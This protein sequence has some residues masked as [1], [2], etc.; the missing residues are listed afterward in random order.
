MNCE[1][2]FLAVGDASKAGDAIV[3]RYGDVSAYELMIVDA[4]NLDSGRDLVNHIRKEFGA[5]SIISHVVLTHCDAD[6]ASGLREVLAELNVRN[7][8]L[9]IPWLCAEAARPYF[10]E[11][12][13]SDNQVA[14]AIRKEYGLIDEIVKLALNKKINIFQP[15]A[16]LK[17]GPFLVVSPY[18][19]A[20]EV[21]LPQFNR[22]PDPDQ[23]AIEALGWWIGKP[24]SFFFKLFE[25]AAATVQRWV[26]ETW[27][28]EILKDGGVTSATNESSV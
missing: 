18:Q 9:H 15:F 24:P 4:G 22:T 12:N 16:G 19:R 8:W 26:T 27:E 14:S 1:I 5:S 7:L 21:L 25:K 10:A 13:W 17:V 3:I 6:H 20:Y 28:G 23:A 2:E 11:K